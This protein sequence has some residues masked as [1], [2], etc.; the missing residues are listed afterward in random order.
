MA[1]EKEEKVS[2]GYHCV[3]QIH[4]HIVF[5]VKYRKSPLMEAM[6]CDKN[7]IHLLCGAHPK[8][9]P[10]RIVQIFKSIT[11]REIFR[12]KP[13]VKKELWGGE[14]WIDGYYVGTVGEHGNWDTVERYVKRQSLDLKDL[15]QLKL[16]DF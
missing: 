5:P 16:F 4:Y 12:R 15:R 11:A 10:W 1:D 2:R 13:A 9:A 14:F 8:M 3:W 6:G 7:H